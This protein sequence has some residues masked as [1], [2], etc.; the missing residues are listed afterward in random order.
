M[1]GRSSSQV[2]I[3][4]FGCRLACLLGLA[5]VGT[6]VW[7]TSAGADAY[8][9]AKRPQLAPVPDGSGSGGGV[10]PNATVAHGTF[11]CAVS[12]ATVAN[13]PSGYAIGNCHS[14]THLHRTLKSDATETGYYDG[15]E[16]FGNYAGCG[17]IGVGSDAALNT[18]DIW[19]NCY[20]VAGQA[21]GSF[22]TSTD[23]CTGGSNCA[24][25]PF[26][27]PATCYEWGNFRPWLSGQNPSDYLR[28]VAAH[29]PL[30]WRYF[31]KY[32]AAN[33]TG[34]YLMVRDRSIPAGS[35]NWVFVPRY[36]TGL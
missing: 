26:D 36:C 6:Y 23:G 3:R 19:S 35:G 8:L 9:V 20:P 10:T 29:A 13:K 15:G 27:P 4:A 21:D 5:A 14:G 12:W 17:W 7:P 22:W 30:S 28:T 25:T 31:T 24:G 16:I 18:T 11:Q 1:L 33:A 32:T 34:Q 2:S